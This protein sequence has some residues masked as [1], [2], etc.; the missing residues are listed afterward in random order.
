MAVT[1][2]HAIEGFAWAFAYQALGTAPDMSAAVRYSFSAMTA[3]GHARILLEWERW[4][5]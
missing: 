5:H 3:Y 2:L 1:V 4:R